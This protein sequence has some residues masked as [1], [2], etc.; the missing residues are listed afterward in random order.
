MQFQSKHV[1]S[2]HQTDYRSTDHRSVVYKLEESPRGVNRFQCVLSRG[3]LF[4]PSR[5]CNPAQTSNRLSA[6][7]VIC[8]YQLSFISLR[9]FTSVGLMIDNCWKDADD[10]VYYKVLWLY[11][12]PLLFLSVIYYGLCNLNCGCF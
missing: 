1:S 6:L 8:S 9:S 4:V 10:Y 5:P 7:N 2:F 3:N 11:F 12:S